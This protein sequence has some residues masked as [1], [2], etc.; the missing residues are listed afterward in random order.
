MLLSTKIIDAFSLLTE[1]IEINVFGDS[2]ASH[3]AKI[4][5]C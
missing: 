3:S 4:F 1:E 5:V 2:R